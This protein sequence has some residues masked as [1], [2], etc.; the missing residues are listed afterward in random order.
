MIVSFGSAETKEFHHGRATRV[1]WLACANV[2]R[3]KLDA[4]EAARVVEDLRV[5]PGTRL[6]ALSGDRAGK[7][8]IRVNSQW[9][10]CFRWEADGAR[11]VEVVDY[12]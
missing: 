11:E 7:H 8:S 2:A 3:R 1:P 6:E 12:H 10:S 4:I 5:P 9:R